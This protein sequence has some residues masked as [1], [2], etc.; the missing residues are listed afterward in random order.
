MVLT[1]PEDDEDML[2]RNSSRINRIQPSSNVS[3]DVIN[4]GKIVEKI[5]KN[6]WTTYWKT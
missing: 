1:M 2:N 4:N 5:S 3:N 6:R